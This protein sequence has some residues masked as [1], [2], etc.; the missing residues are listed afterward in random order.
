MLATSLQ[1]LML[2][3]CYL[4]PAILDIFSDAIRTSVSLHEVSLRGNEFSKKA[5]PPLCSMLEIPLA[6][7]ELLDCSG[8]VNLDLSGNDLR[9][10]IRLLSKT[11]LQNNQLQ[12]LSLLNCH[13]DSPSLVPLAEALVSSLIAVCRFRSQY[14]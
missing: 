1:T 7:K 10:G 13:L 6:P 9:H 3:S 12:T 14:F 5:F 4:S 2:D 8:L 11:L